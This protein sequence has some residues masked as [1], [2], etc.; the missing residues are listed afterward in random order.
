[1]ALKVDMDLLIEKARQGD[2]AAFEELCALQVERLR[3][4]IRARMGSH[5]RGEIDAE[6]V[7]Q[8][9]WIEAFSAIAHY[10]ARGA[11]SF[12]RWLNGIAEHVILNA[13]RRGRAR[14]RALLFLERILPEEDLTA[15]KGVRREE[16]MDRLQVA[17]D[18]LPPEY[19]EAIWLVRIEG[20]Q[21]KEAASRMGRSPKA[22]MHLLA[23]GLKKLKEAFGDTESLGLPHRGL[24]RGEC[25][26][27]A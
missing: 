26:R 18:G 8:E 21:V 20:L 10:R 1:M 7:L 23:R 27:E 24:E 19:R 25:D 16:R 15:S 4:F 17:L 13:A 12:E 3:G 9:T 6:D 11:G 2:R 14:A 22:V 5:L